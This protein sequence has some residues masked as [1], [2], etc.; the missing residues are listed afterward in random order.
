M[1]W[2]VPWCHVQ[3]WHDAECVVYMYG[4]SSMMLWQD[5]IECWARHT[6]SPTLGFDI[7]LLYNDRAFVKY[8]PWRDVLDYAYVTAWKVPWS[9][10][11][12]IVCH[13]VVSWCY[14][15]YDVA[16]HSIMIGVQSYCVILYSSTMDFTLFWSHVSCPFYRCLVYVWCR[17]PWC[18][19]LLYTRC[20]P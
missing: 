15:V 9:Y 17:V 12:A 18:S 14:I 20:I 10:H 2:T 13:D 16:V 3:N 1:L 4:Y 6:W 11:N 5:L 8:L 19:V 7:H